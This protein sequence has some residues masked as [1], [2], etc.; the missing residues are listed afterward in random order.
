MFLLDGQLQQ[1]EIYTSEYSYNFFILIHVIDFRKQIIQKQ[2]K[3][4]VNII[5]YYGGEI[6]NNGDG[7][8]VAIFLLELCTDG[9]LFDLMLKYET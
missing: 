1:I 7:S 5:N 6:K 3:D 8:Y 4:S 9:S 2:C